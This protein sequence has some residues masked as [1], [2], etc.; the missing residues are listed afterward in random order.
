MDKYEKVSELARRRGFLFP[1]FE[2]YGGVGGFYDYGPLGTL[3]KR[4]IENKWRDL[5]VRR[6]GMVEIEA[7]VIMPSTVFEA[8]GHVAHF[9]D[10]MT[11][12]TRCGRAYRTDTVLSE[13]GVSFPE[14]ASMEMLD[15]LVKEHNVRCPECGGELTESQPFNLM[16]RVY[17]GPLGKG[18]VGY[19][20]PEAAQGQF[21]DFKRVYAAERERLPLGIAQI[22]RAMRN[23]IAP[24]KGPIRLREFTIIDY[25]VFVDPEDM[26]YP[27]IKKV[28]DVKLRILP[29]EEQ[30]AGTNR[31]Y[32]VT[33]REALEK[34]FIKNE[35]HAYFL[36]LSTIFMQQLGIPLDKQR[37]REQLPE[38]RAH[39]SMQTFDQEVW[40]ERWGWVEVSG[41]AYRTDYDLSRHMMYSGEDL[42]V[43][44]PFGEK[45]EI[46]EVIAIPNEGLIK[47]DFGD[48]ASFVLT[49]LKR[50]V[51]EIVE[52][53]LKQKGFYELPGPEPLV[54]KP[55]HVSFERR[56][57]M[58]SGRHFIP[59]VVEPSFGVDRMFYVVMEYA[60]TEKGDRVVL[61][62]PRDL[63]PIQVAVFPLVTRDGLPEKAKEVY[64]LLLDEG[65]YVDYDESGSI[66]RRYARADEIGVPICVTVDYQTLE[67]ETVTLRDRDT[68]KQVRTEI[69]PLPEKLRKYFGYRMEFP[70]LGIPVE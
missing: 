65:F 62:L 70:E 35:V 20:R 37:F 59:H 54:L 33:V 16:F 51:P 66:G 61:K 69:P 19:G 24:R 30:L 18:I 42:R 41:H 3:L 4:N 9:T 13:V 26:S 31:V 56:K 38:E 12:C 50:A 21:V 39:Y 32:E 7:T 5:F 28:E 11:T 58:A 34:G 2:I 55:E 49:M 43:F 45:R 64:E 27:R 53:E 47:R 57:V 17:I 25:E 8:S 36:A 14:G 48:K 10:A 67:D 29:A 1:A 44:K 40:T 60:Y 63:A 6:E 15:A 23:E 68:W 52:R 46:E 22:G